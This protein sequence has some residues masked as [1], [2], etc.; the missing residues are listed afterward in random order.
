MMNCGHVNITPGLQEE[1]NGISDS[2]I[3]SSTGGQKLV[4][5]WCT[6]GQQADLPHSHQ[7]V[8]VTHTDVDFLVFF[9]CFSSEQ[10]LHIQFMM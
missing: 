10:L 1:V 7:T 2:K 8:K 9:V 4:L 5:D 6:A 3:A